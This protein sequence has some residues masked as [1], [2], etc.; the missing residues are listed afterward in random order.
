LKAATVVVLLTI[1]LIG[2]GCASVSERERSVCGGFLEP[3][4]FALWSAMAP[5]PDPRR[6]DGIAGVKPYDFVAGDGNTL[7][8]YMIQARNDRDEI[9]ENARGYVLVAPGNAMAATHLAADFV[10]LSE[11]GYDVYVLDYRGYANSEGKRRL[12]ALTVDYAELITHLSAKY[13]HT[14]LLGMSMGGIVILKAIHEGAPFTRAI[15]D[16][17]PST[18]TQFLCPKAFN[19]IANLPADPSR[20]LIITAGRDRVIPP[21][22][23]EELVARAQAAGAEVF[24]CAECRHPLADTDPELLARRF[25][26]IARFLSNSSERDGM[27]QD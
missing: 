23:S 17:S 20:L 14:N 5:N 10:F 26:E 16:S 8:G 22:A 18:V 13:T 4:A 3:L 25:R 9:I 15:V 19:P 27:T 11:L 1:G 24:T 21:T 12:L 6:L 2:G 7:R